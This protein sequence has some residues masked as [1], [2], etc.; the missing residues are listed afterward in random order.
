MSEKQTIP[1]PKLSFLH[2]PGSHIQQMLRN[3]PTKDDGI[4]STYPGGRKLSND[5]LSVLL[6][7]SEHQA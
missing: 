2:Q 5:V 6:I 4:A 1:I 3:Y 7:L